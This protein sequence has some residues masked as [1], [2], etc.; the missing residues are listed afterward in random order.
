MV[1]LLEREHKKLL[2]V[3]EVMRRFIALDGA[4]KEENQKLSPTVRVCFEELRS[5]L[6]KSGDV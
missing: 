1:F 6:I 3:H 5:A 2:S 4:L